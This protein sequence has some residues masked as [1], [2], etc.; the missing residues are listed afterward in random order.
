MDN[1]LKQ[2]LVG[3]V[4]LLSLFIIF[5]PMLLD[6][7]DPTSARIT[8]TNIPAKPEAEFSSRVIPLE[9]PETIESVEPST[10]EA[11]SGSLPLVGTPGNGSV[12]AAPQSAPAAPSKPVTPDQER[13]GLAAWVVQVGSFS[14]RDN[15]QQLSEKLVGLGFSAFVEE[16]TSGEGRIYRVRIGPEL[17]RSNAEAIQTQLAEKAKLEGVVLRYP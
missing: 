16:G 9:Q 6:G 15:A 2:R 5:V 17:K 8:V 3:L 1:S 13:V 12:T 10:G 7:S 11:S 4:V 14:A